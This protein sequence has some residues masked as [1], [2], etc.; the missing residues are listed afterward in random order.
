MSNISYNQER[1]ARPKKNNQDL[2]P[3]CQAVVDLRKALG[4][5]QQEMAFT[6]GVAVT[7]IARY[8]TGR[9]PESKLLAKLAFVAQRRGHGQIADVLRSEISEVL[10][11]ETV[12]KAPL[13]ESHLIAARSALFPFIWA[14][15]EGEKLPPIEEI[16]KAAI[17][18][19]DETSKASK[20][21][22]ELDP[23]YEINRALSMVQLNRK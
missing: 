6:F 8:E 4:L 5:T 16:G 3:V 21:L 7:T 22:E 18:A 12:H 10:G 1:M 15:R 19:Y 20:L 2:P 13:I 17:S 9:I 14:F 11:T 23:S